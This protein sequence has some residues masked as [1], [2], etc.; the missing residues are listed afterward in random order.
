MAAPVMPSKAMSG[1]QTSVPMT[2]SPI[3]G[4]LWSRGRPP[5]AGTGPAATG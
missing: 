5:R 2:P 1:A 3:A 4:E